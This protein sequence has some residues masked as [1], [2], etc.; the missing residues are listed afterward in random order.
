MCWQVLMMLLLLGCVHGI[1]L[2]SIEDEQ[3]EALVSQQQ[4]FQ[5]QINTLNEEIS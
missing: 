4:S 5:Q 1:H 3:Y 2:K